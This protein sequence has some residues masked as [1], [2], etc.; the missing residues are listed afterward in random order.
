M[1]KDMI[2][3]LRCPTCKNKLKMQIKKE[4]EN[5]IIKGKLNCPKCNVN[6]PIKDGIPDLLPKK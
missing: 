6:Y 1:K 4:K 5:H 3:I 2:K